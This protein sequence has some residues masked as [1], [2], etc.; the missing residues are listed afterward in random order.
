MTTDNVAILFTDIVGSTDL[1]QRLSPDAAD[2]VRRRHFS[3]LRQAIAEADG[4]EVKNLGDGLMVVFGTGSMALACGVAMQQGVERDNRGQEHSVGLR[5]GLSGGEVTREDDDYFGDP[6]VEA[7]RLCARCESGQVLAADV[8]RAMAG[9][10]NRHTCRSVGALDL[11][12]L[13]SAV[14]T[15]EVLWEPLEGPS[16]EAALPLPDRLGVHPEV[17]VV[18]R[19]AELDAISH[20][21]SRVAGG[22]GREVMFVSGEAGL[23][24]TTLVAQAARTAFGSGACVLFGHCE[25]DLAT[26]YQLFGEALGH[27]VTHA[28]EDLLLNHVEA[29]G[30]DLARL[31][32]A[33]SIRI[34]HLPPTKGTDS[35]TER[36]LFFAAAV[37]LLATISRE[38]PVCLVLDDLQW[39]DKGSLLLLRH[40]AASETPLRLLVLGTYRDGELSHAHP[41]L[42]TLAALRRQRG[43]SRIPLAGLDDAGVLSMLKVAAGQPLSDKAKGL[44]LAV[45]RETDGNPFFVSEVLRHLTEIGVIYEDAAGQWASQDGLAKMALPDSVREVIG[46]RVG[47]LGRDAERVLS[48]AAVIG[49]DF[50]LDLLAGVTRTAE[51]DL[52]DILDTAAA[53]SLVREVPDSAGRY[54]FTHAL[55]QHTLYDDLGPSRRARSHH[56]LAEA[57]E[58]L[59][60][61]HPGNRVGELARHWFLATQP[62]DVDKALRYSRQAADAALESLA[63]DEAV[64]YYSQALDLSQRFDDPN[65]LVSLDLTIGMGIAQR[66]AGDASFR[67][68]LL[69]AA[70][71]AAALD[72]TDRLVAAA[73]ANNRG[74]FSVIGGIDTEKVAVLE[75]ALQRL[76]VDRPERALVLA[77]LCQELTYGSP[78]ERRR[79]LAEEALRIVENSGDDALIVRVLNHIV[80]PLRVPSMLDRSQAW[81]ERA[82]A[83]AKRVDDP[84]LLFWAAAFRTGTVACLGDIDELDHCIGIIEQLAERV[85]QSTMHW[86]CSFVVATRALIAGDLE[87]ANRLTLDALRIATENAEPDAEVFFGAQLISMKWQ[88]GT[89]GSAISLIDQ[90]ASDNPGIPTFN[91]TLAC[92]YAEGGR[93]DEAHDLLRQLASTDF[94]L[95]VD[96]TWMTGM[97]QSAEAAIVCSDVDCASQLIERLASWTDLWSYDDITTEGPVSHYVGGLTAILGDFDRANQYFAKAASMNERMGAKFFAARTNLLWGRMLAER[98][99]PGDMDSARELI[100][101]ARA[102]AIAHGFGTVERRAADA[103]ILLESREGLP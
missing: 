75:E 103:L 73:L 18:G 84:V 72:D 59:C 7:A 70:R 85:D 98:N 87:R 62:I 30:S 14:E 17:G 102:A 101:K 1:S 54:S 20:A 60:G 79:D 27:Y 6:V 23:G 37:G 96:T 64:R 43:I 53:A 38:Q 65:P 46:A 16:L 78:L 11:K 31:V 56:Q 47:R 97:V 48:L 34:P 82:L 28:S 90:T 66:Q 88:Q 26:P 12:G 42:D 57:L 44:A 33:L 13:P 24:K 19:E 5:V 3:I 67:E 50:D 71:Q 89:M 9:R 77:T 81:T 21:M 49:R 10:R 55:V 58:D 91:A 51:D 94:D 99:A 69:E 93:N 52:L 2:E 76:S 41:L 45:H 74:F 29:H 63:P 68:T 25:E 100:T 36:F 80:L 95:P 32:P 40:L 86:V 35:D 92:A 61:G 22:N 15:V 8:V 4:V 39:A 83:L